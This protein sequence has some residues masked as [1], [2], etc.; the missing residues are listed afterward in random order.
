ME[1]YFYCSLWGQDFDPTPFLD[2]NRIG[3]VQLEVS[4]FSRVGDLGTTGTM[5][6]RI[7]KTGDILLEAKEGNFDEFVQRVYS[8]KDLII[9]SQAERRVLH[10]SL[11]YE[12]QCN[13]EFGPGILKMISEMDLKLTLT[14]AKM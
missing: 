3:K 13:W 12:D 11:W 6:G 2:N 9:E 10:I 7:L 8:I 4:K 14:C 1:I 5:K